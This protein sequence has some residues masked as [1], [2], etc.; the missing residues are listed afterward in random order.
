MRLNCSSNNKVSIRNHLDWIRNLSMQNPEDVIRNYPQ[1]AIHLQNGGGL[2][3]S[4]NFSKEKW[5][6]LLMKFLTST[7]VGPHK[8]LMKIFSPG[9]DFSSV[10][11]SFGAYCLHSVLGTG[12]DSCV[13]KTVDGYCLK[14]VEYSRREKLKREYEILKNL[15]HPNIV[16]CFEFICTTGYAA[17]LMETLSPVLGDETVYIQALDYCHSQGILHGDIRLNN[18]GSDAEGRSKLFDFGNAAVIQSQSEGQKEIEILKNIMRS[19]IAQ[20]RKATSHGD[21]LC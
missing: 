11:L 21:V 17:I 5:Q 12:S 13:Y 15:H 18:L 16:K 9:Y 10:N 8:H 1:I 14:V 2:L 20:E 3:C 7:L 19:P 4:E 6:H